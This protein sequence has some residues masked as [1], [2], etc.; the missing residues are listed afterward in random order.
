MASRLRDPVS[1]TG[2]APHCR[3]H[4]GCGEVAQRTQ[5]FNSLAQDG[6]PRLSG[7]C[8]L[9]FPVP[10]SMGPSTRSFRPTRGQR[11]CYHPI[12]KDFSLLPSPLPRV[13]SCFS[14]SKARVL[15]VSDPLL[16][17]SKPQVHPATAPSSKPSSNGLCPC[18][19]CFHIQS[20][21][22]AF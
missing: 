11:F 22:R 21:V 5:P 19:E 17:D 3:P 7:N 18:T 1:W 14:S 10:L 6:P 20:L 2:P 9:V 16:E 4:C 12:A 15:S 13:A 8:L